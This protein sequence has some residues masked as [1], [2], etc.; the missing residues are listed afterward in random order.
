MT[1]PVGVAPPGRSRLVIVTPWRNGRNHLPPGG[2][3]AE[4]RVVQAVHVPARDSWVMPF[5]HELSSPGVAV[6][7]LLNDPGGTVATF[8]PT[9]SPRLPRMFGPARLPP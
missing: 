1:G 3:H 4:I 5:A 8:S 9:A 2:G 6:A 7:G